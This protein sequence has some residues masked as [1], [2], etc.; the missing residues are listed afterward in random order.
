MSVTSCLGFCAA[1]QRRMRRL[2][3][4]ECALRGLALRAVGRE[5]DHLL[6]RLRVAPS[7][8][9][10]PNARDDAD[11]QQRLRRAWDRACSDCSNWASA[12]SG[13]LV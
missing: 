4:V 7:R 9:C 8:S 2:Q 10:L 1:A 13:W 6:P 12:L 5:R 11:V 3:A